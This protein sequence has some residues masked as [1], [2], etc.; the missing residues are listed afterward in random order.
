MSELLQIQQYLA[1]KGLGFI[2]P[3]MVSPTSGALVIEVPRDRVHAKSS[4]GK[5]SRRQLAFVTRSLEKKFGRRVL[6]TIRDAQTLDDVAA[7]LRAVLRRK[8]PAIVADV[9]VSFVDATTAVV[10]IES[11]TIADA[12][13][14]EPVYLATQAEL[15]D[16]GVRCE[17]FDVVKPLLPEPST[18]A[19]LRSV[20]TFAPA[21]LSAVVADLLRRGFSCPSEKW[22]SYKLDVARKRGLVVRDPM[23]RFTLTADGLDVVPRSRSSSSSDVERM[24]VLARR[25]SW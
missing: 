2:V 3:R 11:L 10:W 8:F 14:V 6:V 7:S 19:I 12:A 21:S 5:T 17:A 24:L 20:K 18:I 9:H 22:L 1:S 15:A 16:F 23:G 13:A 25:K 4:S